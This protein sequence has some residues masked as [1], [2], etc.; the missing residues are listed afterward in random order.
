ME[1]KRLQNKNLLKAK[2]LLAVWDDSACS[3]SCD[4]DFTT[5]SES[6]NH[7]TYPK[8]KGHIKRNP[9][10]L[11]FVVLV[12]ANIFSYFCHRNQKNVLKYTCNA[13]YDLQSTLTLNYE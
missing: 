6:E 2:V 9:F 13:N 7:E 4:S 10:R 3:R 11:E 5:L 12:V 1:R 8:C